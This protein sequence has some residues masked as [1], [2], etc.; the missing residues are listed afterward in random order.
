MC[1]AAAVVQD[2]TA[3]GFGS[4][5]AH[6]VF[7]DR[8]FSAVLSRSLDLRVAADATVFGLPGTI[9][10]DLVWIANNRA[11]AVLDVVNEVFHGELQSADIGLID[12]VTDGVARRIAGL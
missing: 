6:A 7:L 10:V 9:I 1:S 8:R 2:L 5:S 4:V 12:Q 11:I 3:S